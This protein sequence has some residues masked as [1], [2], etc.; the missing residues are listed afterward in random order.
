M[1]SGSPWGLTL[2]VEA[3]LSDAS[4]EAV[5]DAA[6]RESDGI[7]AAGQSEV[8][9]GRC[10]LAA[11]ALSRV[12]EYRP[13]RQRLGACMPGVPASSR[14]GASQ[15]AAPEKR[16]RLP[17]VRPSSPGCSPRRLA[18][19]LPTNSCP[20]R[21]P[22]Q[23]ALCNIRSALCILPVRLH[24]TCQYPGPR[25]PL[26][27]S[28]GEPGWYKELRVFVRGS[29]SLLQPRARIMVPADEA[30]HQNGASLSGSAGSCRPGRSGGLATVRASLPRRWSGASS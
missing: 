30:A 2:S 4:S 13:P 5:P 9:Y 26:P 28:G 8:A 22:V 17:A 14:P 18:R 25:H 1:V 23:L 12:R 6:E 19:I 3:V 16:F 21:S 11:L 24:F 20:V 27:G 29:R 7:G 10:A 15:R